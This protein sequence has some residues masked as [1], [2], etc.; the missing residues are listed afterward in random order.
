MERIMDLNLTGRT[1]LVTGASRG[2]GRGIAL[3]LAREGVRLALVARH[4]ELLREVAAEI[5]GEGGSEPLLIIEDLLAEAAPNR[6]ARAALDGLGSVDM[7]I[8]NAGGSRPFKRDAGEEQWQEAMTLNFTRQRQ[9]TH[10]LLDQMIER[11]WGRIVNITGK[12]EPEGING[13]FCAK[14][15]LHSWA[16][17]LSREVGKYGITVNS[18]PPGR[19]MSEQIRRNYTPE[20][21]RWQADNEI[22]V[23][24]YGEPEDVAHLVCLLVS[25]LAG[26]ITGTVIPVDGGLRRYQF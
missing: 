26:Y 19:I 18:I 15:A 4:A 12:S 11:K 22:P 6:I 13:A 23:G 17:G 24:R 10:S 3:A 8:N 1:G 16:K 25:P 9:L 20:Y 7:L 2:I 21:R 14:A 5:R